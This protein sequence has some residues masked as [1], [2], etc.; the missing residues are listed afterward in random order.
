MPAADPTGIGQSLP[1]RDIHLPP[2][3]GWWP[4]AP[5]WWL[6]A[7]LLAV[8][9]L[10]SLLLW[11]RQ[12]R[13]RY[14]RQALHQLIRLE[15]RHELTGHLLLAELSML[16]RRA[17]LSAFPD[18]NCAGLRDEAWLQFLDRSLPDQQFLT[19]AGRCLASGPY[20]YT[21]EIDRE[22]LLS[23]CRRWLRR[24]PPTPRRRR[25]R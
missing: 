25:A 24:L 6:L 23:L 1:L 18:E 2:A 21:V 16:L 12:R 4:P 8:L 20:Q 15:Q 14:R 22:A 9:L 5:G 10:V 7:G 3:P 11:R 13:L 17:A 19:G